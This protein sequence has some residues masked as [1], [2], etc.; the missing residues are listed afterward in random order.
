MTVTSVLFVAAIV[1]PG[2]PTGNPALVTTSA[3]GQRG[4]ALR[5]STSYGVT[6]RQ[7]IQSRSRSR[8]GWPPWR[9]AG[10]LANS[11]TA[12]KVSQARAPVTWWRTQAGARSG[13]SADATAVSM[14]ISAPAVRCPRACNTAR[15][16]GWTYLPPERRIDRGGR[17]PVTP[18]GRGCE[19]TVRNGAENHRVPWIAAAQDRRTTSLWPW[20]T[21]WD[22]A[23]RPTG[24]KRSTSSWTSVSTGQQTIRAAS[25]QRGPCCRPSP[26][27]GRGQGSRSVRQ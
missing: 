15:V 19:I 5:I 7:V 14:T 4:E 26:R 16:S 27:R 20:T 18:F 13:W 8:R 9:G 25:A 6:G 17:Q 3:G 10:H 1:A 22:S 12:T 11:L 24:F 21:D 23:T 2:S